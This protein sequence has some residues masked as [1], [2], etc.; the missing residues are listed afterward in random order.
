M[1]NM[2][3]WLMVICGS[4]MLGAAFTGSSYF[5]VSEEDVIFKCDTSAVPSD[6][7]SNIVTYNTYKKSENGFPFAF[8]SKESAA[9]AGG[10]QRQYV[11]ASDGALAP[12]RVDSQGNFIDYSQFNKTEFAKDMAIWSAV[13]LIL[14]IFVFGARKKQ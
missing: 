7:N 13:F 4:L 12:G 1:N 10:C 2:K 3:T 5:V 11:S 9:K 8:I 14:G 6:M